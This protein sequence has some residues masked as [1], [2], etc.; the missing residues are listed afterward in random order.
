MNELDY[1]SPLAIA[2][3]ARGRRAYVMDVGPMFGL[4]DK[5][6]HRIAYVV[7][8]KAQDEQ[9]IVRG[10]RHAQ[11]AAAEGGVGAKRASEDIDLLNEAKVCELLHMVCREPAHPEDDSKGASIH[12]AFPGPKWMR[13]N[14]S[15]DDLARLLNQYV[16]AKERDAPYRS[17]ITDDAVE[18]MIDLL[19]EHCD[20]EVPEAVLASTTRT[21][22]THLVTLLAVKIVEARHKVEVLLDERDERET[23]QPVATEAIDDGD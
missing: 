15:T 19:S 11:E 21:Y 23:A 13:E 6:K 22:L 1:K 3:E 12:S 14:L 8:T 9:A 17:V 16:E 20:D 2:I 18:Q 4:T 10:H 5:A 7:A